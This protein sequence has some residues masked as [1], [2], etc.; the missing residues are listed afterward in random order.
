[1]QLSVEE[2]L[3]ALLPVLGSRP[4]SGHNLNFTLTLLSNYGL[5]ANRSE[6]GIRH[7]DRGASHG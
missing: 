3:A 6:R 1:M 4:V 2:A 7:D 5:A